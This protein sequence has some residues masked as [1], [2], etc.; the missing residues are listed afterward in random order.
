MLG[1]DIRASHE[2]NELVI[3]SPPL[4]VEWICEALKSRSCIV[5]TTA[6]VANYV[7]ITIVRRIRG[8]KEQ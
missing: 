2:V 4:T 1:C 3:H 7:V 8:L 5:D 6:V